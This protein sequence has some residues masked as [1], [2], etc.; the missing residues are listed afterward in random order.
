MESTPSTPTDAPSA[1]VLQSHWNRVIGRRGFLLGVGS[2]GAT[3]LAG[4]A[5]S[6][7]DAFAGSGGLSSGDE[8]ILLRR[9]HR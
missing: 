7:A 2:V 1:D 4:G 5:L 8:A 6:T 3:A 9:N